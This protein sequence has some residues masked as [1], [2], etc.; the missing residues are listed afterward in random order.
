MT[1]VDIQCTNCGSP[2]DRRRLDR[3]LAVVD[4]INCGTMVDLIKAS[5]NSKLE[6]RKWVGETLEEQADVLPKKRVLAYKPK[7]FKAYK[8]A[9]EVEFHI[10]RST[11][12]RLFSY[13]VIVVLLIMAF[14]S[15]RENNLLFGVLG[16]II[17]AVLY[18]YG[19]MTE[20]RIK[21]SRSSLSLWQSPSL[22]QKPINVP[23][24][25][26]KQI[27][28]SKTATRHNNT[29]EQ[30]IIHSA[31]R[32]TQTPIADAWSLRAILYDDSIHDVITH[33]P[34][35]EEALYLEQELELQLG[36]RDAPVGS[37]VVSN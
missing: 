28:V 29:L 5:G 33:F 13:A 24:N 22:F 14:A 25:R 34:T 27:F 20:Y 6:V 8:K 7:H 37:E 36:I 19:F 35:L 18:Y 1:T 23:A 11:A 30:L 17:A 21:A 2:V 26:I 3:R 31:S 10:P 15:F 32:E 12:I 4:C 9:G 16:I